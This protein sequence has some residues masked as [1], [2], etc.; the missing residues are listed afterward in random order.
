M[1]TERKALI[2]GFL[3][4]FD[5]IN[6]IEE[7]SNNQKFLLREESWLDYRG[8]GCGKLENIYEVGFKSE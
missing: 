1:P 5:Q 7:I 4:C 3:S 8:C 6:A 2:Y